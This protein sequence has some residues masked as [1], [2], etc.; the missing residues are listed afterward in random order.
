MSQEEKYE[1][2][3]SML[4][5]SLTK[6]EKLLFDEFM[7]NPE[8]K[9]EY[10]EYCAFQNEY[11]KLIKNQSAEHDFISN[12][13]KIAAENN[14]ANKNEIVN[15]NKPQKES[16]KLTFTRNLKW[17]LSAAAALIL[18]F[19]GY[20]HFFNAKQSMPQLYASNFKLEPLSMERG[21]G[22]DSLE[23]IL[24]VYNN[25][26]YP[27]ALPLL[28]QYNTAHVDNYNTKIALAISLMETNDN[29]KSESIL[30]S[31]ILENNAY[32]EKAQWYLGPELYK[33]RKKIRGYKL[34]FKF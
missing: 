6:D 3:E 1:L 17:I 34:T 26:N 11:A 25:K 30:K 10:E 16:S 20:Q 21:N 2:F 24:K 33:A 29:A 13:K 14:S 7:Q 5:N 27:A 4:D 31:I 12:L 19:F 28:E 18:G 9:L 23:A 22:D 8:F 15:E 32:K